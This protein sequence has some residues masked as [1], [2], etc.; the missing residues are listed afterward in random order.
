MFVQKGKIGEHFLTG[1]TLEELIW[2]DFLKMV[3]VLNTSREAQRAFLTII[4]FTGSM[5]RLQVGSELAGLAVALPTLSTHI[6]S[7]SSVSTHMP[8]QLDGLGKFS[9]AIL[10]RIH[11]TLGVLLL[12]VVSKACSHSEAHVTLTT[13]IGLFPCVQSLMVLQ[14]GLGRKLRTTYFT[15]KGFLIQMLTPYVV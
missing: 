2:V 15:S 3:I 5:C 6:R 9:F 7:V 1:R 8:C 4:R 13:G 10:T 14:G 11:V 12:D